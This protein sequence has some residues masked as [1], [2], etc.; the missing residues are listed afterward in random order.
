ML[1]YPECIALVVASLI[2]G[3]A[4]VDQFGS[5]IYDGN[6]NSQSALNQETVLNIVRASRYQPLS[7]VAITQVTGGQMEA[8]STGLPTISLGPH[9]PV[10]DQVYQISN[11]LSSQFS[12]GYQSNPLI[13]TQFQDGMLSP[14][15]L[16]T[17]SQLIASHPRETVFYSLVT[18]LLLPTLS[19]ERRRYW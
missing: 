7:F 18:K 11:S 14:V 4:T 15:P 13:S 8:L 16:R 1:R 3:C 2:S 12:G 9:Q 17:L 6:I 19:Q 5:R 10:N